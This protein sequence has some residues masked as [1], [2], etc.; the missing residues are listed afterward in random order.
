MAKSSCGASAFEELY[1]I[2]Y[3]KGEWLKGLVLVC[4]STVLLSCN[5]LSPQTSEPK[6][7]NPADSD[8]TSPKSSQPNPS[9]PA[10]FEAEEITS[11]AQLIP[12]AITPEEVNLREQQV[13]LAKEIDR[14]QG[15]YEKAGLSTRKDTLR[16]TYRRL[17]SEIQ[18][19][20][21]KQ[22]FRLK[23][24]EGKTK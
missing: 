10:S 22:L 14:L 19:L 18:L 16:E 4:L 23:Q 7:I 3:A 8:T 17:N 20:Q 1:M 2:A 15:L 11:P 24:Q 5:T 9:P 21:A 6:Q 12:S 13:Q